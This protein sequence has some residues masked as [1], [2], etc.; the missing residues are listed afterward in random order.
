MTITTR[1]VKGSPLS[2]TE[3]DNNFTGLQPRNTV[4]TDV[5]DADVTLTVITSSP[6]QLYSTTLTANR[7]ITL[8]T[9][10]AVDG[11]SFRVVRTG[12]G[13][14]TLDVG[15]LKTIANATAA[16]VDVS[17]NGTA[18]ILTGYGAL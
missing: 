6:I 16:F 12:L 13:A 7:T 9:T 5:G 15:G 18:W 4:G 3:M 17:Y 1:S 10:N 8:S 11:D 2:H 14:F